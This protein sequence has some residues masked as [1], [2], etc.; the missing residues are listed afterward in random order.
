MCK[1][2]TTSQGHPPARPQ[3][4]RSRGLVRIEVGDADQ[5]ECIACLTAAGEAAIEAALPPWRKAQERI[6]TS[7][8]IRETTPATALALAPRPE[9]N[10]ERQAMGD[11]THETVP[12]QFVEAEGARYAYRRFGKP[13]TV[14]LLFL[15]YFNSNMD[16]WD[17]VVTNS[18]AADHEVILFD[19]AGVGASGGETPYTAVG[20]TPHCV[21]FCR[22]LGLKA[23]HIVGFSLG[24]MIAQ[25]LAL[26]H[27]HLV[28]RLILLGTAP[29]G[30]QGLAF[31]ELSPEEQVDPVAFLLGAFFS[32]SEASQAAGRAYMK[33]L[34]SR[35]EDRDLPVSR[36]SAVAQLAAIR[37]WGTIP[38]TGRYATLQ[39][40][41]HPTLIVH[42]NKD[43]VV[44]PIN[45]LILA[46][47]LPN[48]QLIVYSDS[49]H[50][51]QYQHAKMFLEQVKLFLS[52][53][54]SPVPDVDPISRV[55]THRS[56]AKSEAI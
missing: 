1:Q 11:Y 46:E 55:A 22:A 39:N 31:T 32:P 35:K 56:R 48:A 24:G 40:I 52:E 8:T 10:F 9:R 26:D 20:M 34:G 4:A 7:M 15:E 13:G 36:N 23:I 27:P 5:R 28:Q 43:I 44:A 45:A 47:H 6:E 38:P 51:A 25:Q 42:G 37:E 53:G 3:P 12:T 33:R 50:G 18:L 54:D 41:T 2:R 21:A 19:N 29:R 16:G 49:S 14:P 17:P 30:G